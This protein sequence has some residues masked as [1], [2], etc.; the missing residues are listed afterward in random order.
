MVR[1]IILCERLDGEETRPD[2][3]IHMEHEGADGVFI[4]DRMPAGEKQ[5]G[6]LIKLIKNV[7]SRTDIHMYVYQR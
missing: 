5:E 2:H 3:I 6:R 7:A 4:L 1:E